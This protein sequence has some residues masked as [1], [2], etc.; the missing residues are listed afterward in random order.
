MEGISPTPTFRWSGETNNNNNAFL[1]SLRQILA[2]CEEDRG[3]AAEE[4]EKKV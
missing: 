2:G 3:M 4:A 1:S